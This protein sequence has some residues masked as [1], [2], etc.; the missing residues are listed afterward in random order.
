MILYGFVILFEKIA[1]DSKAW[2]RWSF[3]LPVSNLFCNFQSL[4][5]IL[6]G[7]ATLSQ[8]HKA[9]SK[10]F[11]HPKCLQSA[12]QFS[13]VFQNSLLPRCTFPENSNRLQDKRFLHLHCFQSPLP[14]SG[15]SRD[16]LWP[17][18][19][20][21]VHNNTVRLLSKRFLRRPCL[22]SVLWLF[23]FPF[24]NVLWHSMLFEKVVSA[25]K[26]YMSVYF[27]R[28]VSE[29][30]F[31]VKA[32]FM[33]LYGFVTLLERIIIENKICITASVKK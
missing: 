17:Y 26:A 21:R 12:L 6:Y 11:L 10:H 8:R 22:Q 13:V 9:I 31:D 27:T 2:V 20:L 29:I 14:I 15:V 32:Y 33:I 3:T 19:T 7:L 28:L 18:H 30:L 16:S 25:T 23:P 4:F 24:H 1:T 5:M